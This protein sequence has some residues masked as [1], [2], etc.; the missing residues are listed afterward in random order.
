MSPTSRGWSAAS[1][2]TGCGRSMV[3]RD[4]Q[5]VA[6]RLVA[7]GEPLCMYRPSC[8]A[9]AVRHQ[10]FPA[11]ADLATVSGSRHPR[12]ARRSTFVVG[13]CGSPPLPNVRLA[14]R[15]SHSPPVPRRRSSMAYDLL[16]GSVYRRCGC[17]HR[18]TG[19]S[20]S[21]FP[22]RQ[23]GERGYDGADTPPWRRPSGHDSRSWRCR[24]RSP[25]GGR[26]QCGAGWSS[27]W[28]RYA[29]RSGL[30]RCAATAT[31]YATT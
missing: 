4:H 6:R 20:Q 23:V 24:T 29:T 9:A 17:R 2:R 7:D 16:D 22:R 31:T 18:A 3:V 25:Q 10:P 30:R 14:Y 13:T 5:Y 8:P 21:R 19:T 11:R 1:F 28:Q 26:G 12:P 27:G 15:R